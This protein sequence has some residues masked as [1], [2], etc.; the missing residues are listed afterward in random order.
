MDELVKNKLTAK[1]TLRYQENFDSVTNTFH[2][3][4][5]AV[6]MTMYDDQ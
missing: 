4:D 6:P 5:F 1:K 2:I 3:G